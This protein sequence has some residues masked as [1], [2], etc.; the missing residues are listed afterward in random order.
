[1]STDNESSAGDAERLSLLERLTEKYTHKRPANLDAGITRLYALETEY[2]VLS[3]SAA[4]AADAWAE[5]DLIKARVKNQSVEKLVAG[6]MSRS[7]AEKAAS[8]HE[9]Y[10]AHRDKLAVLEKEKREAETAASLIGTMLHNA[11][12]IVEA[13]ASYSRPITIARDPEFLEGWLSGEINRRVIAAVQSGAA[14]GQ[15]EKLSLDALDRTLEA[16]KPAPVNVREMA[17]PYDN[18]PSM[19]RTIRD[20]KGK[21]GPLAKSELPPGTPEPSLRAIPDL[22]LMTIKVDETKEAYVIAVGTVEKD[23]KHA[24]LAFQVYGLRPGNVMAGRVT[25]NEI[26]VARRR[27]AA[28]EDSYVAIHAAHFSGYSEV[29]HIPITANLCSICG[30]RGA[31]VRHMGESFCDYCHSEAVSAAIETDR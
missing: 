21:R 3:A 30:E 1:M 5:C 24:S 25:E 26:T 10:T 6:G 28:D 20:E 27:I 12:A 22:L 23:G 4:R 7:A 13:Y 2:A 14:V 9:D 19:H 18:V 31:V 16:T 17:D 8:D 29:V 11:R 15:D